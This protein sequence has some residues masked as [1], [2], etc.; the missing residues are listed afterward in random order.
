MTEPHTGLD[1]GREADD[2]G[3]RPGTHL[4]EAFL[5]RAGAADG[6][7][8]VGGHALGA[9]LTMRLVDQFAAGV[10]PYADAVRYQ[11]DATR[12]FLHNLTPQMAETA[13]LLDIV[14]ATDAAH[15]TQDRRVLWG[16]LLRFALWLEDDLRLAE[17]LDVLD[18]ALRLSDGPDAAD[19]LAA[20]L[21]RARICRKATLYAEATAEYARAGETAR[22]LDDHHAERLSRIGRANVM[23]K[24]GNLPGAEEALRAVIAEADAAEDAYA[25]ACASQELANAF[26]LMERPGPA[27]S[28]AFRAYEAYETPVER[29]GAMADVGLAFK[30]LGNYAAA[31]DAFGIV[32][33]GQVPETVRIDTIVELLDVTARIGDR[34][35]FE[36]WRRELMDRDAILSPDQRV[37]FHVALGTGYAAF[38]HPDRAANAL[39]HAVAT[40][41]EHG[42]NARLYLAESYLARLDADEPGPRP[43]AAR[44]TPDDAGAAPTDTDRVADQVHALR[45]AT[46]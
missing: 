6:E 39:R 11:I 20:R 41:A 31:A 40:A 38:G 16:P 35:G 46:V 29:L 17:A 26:R 12:D 42:L 21:Q 2:A 24:V 43:I 18:A 5:E 25:V 4:H 23:Q 8:G 9:F 13:H 14:R 37:D 33:T 15:V 36:R 10:T 27:V 3:V 7:A 30:M 19:E 34:M 32:V 1:P 28:F 44:S 45:L 22:R